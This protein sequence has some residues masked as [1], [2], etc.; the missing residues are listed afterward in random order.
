MTQRQPDRFEKA[1]EDLEFIRDCA[2]KPTPVCESADVL[3]LLRQEHA[4]MRRMVE[5][6]LHECRMG[7][8]RAELT[9]EGT[10][11]YGFR[12]RI[13]QCQ[14]ILDRLTQRRK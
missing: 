2:G 6:R 14:D 3:K 1:V 10:N 13:A 7:E 8:K 12:C 9:G 11:A 4:W 5:T